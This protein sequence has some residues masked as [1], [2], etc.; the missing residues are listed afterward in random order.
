LPFKAF[1][2]IFI[3]KK[4]DWKDLLRAGAMFNKGRIKI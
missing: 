4:R 2:G 3:T 1:F